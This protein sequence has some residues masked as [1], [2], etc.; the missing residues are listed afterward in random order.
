MRYFDKC[1]EEINVLIR[2]AQIE[3]QNVTR[4]VEIFEMSHY[5]IEQQG[6]L[7][8][9]E[10]LNFKAYIWSFTSFLKSNRPFNKYVP[11]KQNYFNRYFDFI[12]QFILKTLLL[13]R[14]LMHIRKNTFQPESNLGY[15]MW[16][17]KKRNYGFNIR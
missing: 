9:K 5:S 8:C 16:L 11:K 2:R 6:C 4:F 12:W 3:G 15:L 10:F 7:L 17:L 1:Y 14:F 13:Y